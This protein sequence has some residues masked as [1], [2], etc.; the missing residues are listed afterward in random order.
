MLLM[1]PE[2]QIMNAFQFL[3]DL[4]QFCCQ[5]AGKTIYFPE[6]WEKNSWSKKVLFIF[7]P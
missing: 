5:N 6:Q 2:R 7:D 1:N 3:W 4:V